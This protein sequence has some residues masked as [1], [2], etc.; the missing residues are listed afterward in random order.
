MS[1]RLGIA[2]VIDESN[3]RT[4]RQ[5]LYLLRLREGHP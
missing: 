4:I 5:A 1:Q 3:R 2:G